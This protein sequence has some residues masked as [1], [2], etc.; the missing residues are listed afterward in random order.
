VAALHRQIQAKHTTYFVVLVDSRASHQEHRRVSIRS[1]L[2]VAAHATGGSIMRRVG[3]SLPSLG[4]ALLVATSPAMGQG[5][6]PTEKLEPASLAGPWQG[7]LR[8]GGETTPFA[9]ELTAA[10]EGKLL[11]KMWV[12]VVHLAGSSLGKLEPKV[13][14]Q[15]IQFGP[16]SFAYD[17]AAGTLSGTIPEGLAPLYRIPLTLR[18][19]PQLDVFPARAEPDVAAAR[20]VWTF[21]TGSPLWPGTTFADGAVYAG[22]DDG[23]LYAL[24]AGTGKLRWSFSSG[25]AIRTRPTVVGGEVYFQADDG[26]LYKVSAASGQERWSVRVVEKTIE[27]LP[28]DNPKSRFDR[29]GSDVTF[30]SGRLYLGT[31]DGRVLALDPARGKRVWEFA[32]GGAVLAAPAVVGGRVYFGSFDNHVYALDAA[33]GRLL[34][35]RDTRAPVVSTPAPTAGRLVVGTRGYDLLALTR[36]TGKLAW[37]RY[38][39]FSWVE[40]SATVRGGV[41]YVGSSD[42]AAAFAFDAATGRPV[43]KA[44]VYG[45]AWGQPAVTEKRVY[46]GTSS[47]PGYLA[48]HRGG[49]L[50]LDRES[51]RV[52]WRFEAEPGK[53]GTYGF[54]GS[55]AVGAGLVFFSGLDGQIYAFLP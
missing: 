2:A 6:D 46:V 20:P 38:L 37:R 44:D 5:L 18:R 16:F 36:A 34:W 51:G 39:W 15:Q 43:W 40:S 49:A 42:A 7:S 35:K 21:A 52:Q 28:F 9:L 50:A 29:F 25:G 48:A 8:H 10:E 1:A 13:E 41:V 54:P 11:V 17:E 22:A 53:A 55:A 14:G 32:S 19:V 23:R 31:H 30:A 4:L 27:R 45:W 47:Q 3:V 12:P 24:D 33:S 26:L